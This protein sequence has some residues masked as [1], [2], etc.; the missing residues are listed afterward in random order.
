M[1]SRGTRCWRRAFWDHFGKIG[2]AVTGSGGRTREGPSL[3]GHLAMAA[4]FI[5]CRVF[6][7]VALIFLPSLVCKGL[8]SQGKGDLAGSS[9]VQPWLGQ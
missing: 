4:D 6:N 7:T 3:D 2:F 1:R 5:L 9:S 8:S